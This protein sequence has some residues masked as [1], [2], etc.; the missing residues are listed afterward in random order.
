MTVENAVTPAASAAA[1]TTETPTAAQTEQ[2]SSSSESHSDKR[3]DFLPTGKHYRLTGEMPKEEA[4]GD[5][6]AA[7]KVQSQKD[8]S[9]EEEASA[10]SASVTAAESETAQAQGKKTKL[11][12]EQRKEQLNAE[13]R[14]LTKQRNELRTPTASDVKAASSPAAEMKLAP[15]KAATPKPRIDDVDPKTNQPRFK[16]YADYEEAKDA[17]ISED[18]VR[19]V[20]EKSAKTA[21]EQQLA[22]VKQTIAREFQKKVDVGRTKYADF[23]AVAL[24]PDL[25][26][27]EGSVVDVF[28]VDS[29]HGQELLYHFGKN[30]QDLERINGMNQIRQAR[31]LTK[32]ELKYENATETDPAAD[33]KAAASSSAKPVTKAPR[34]PHQLSG[35]GTAAKDTISQAVQEGDQETYMREANARALARKRKG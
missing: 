6:E 10:A 33:E 25:P 31:E 4:A 28:L 9:S 3:A 1:T 19:K 29:P 34:P 16:T 11:T 24:N 2:S 26:I 35:K 14:L 21:K 15:V 12:A 7:G 8:T 22:S 23:D 13:I 18:A 30:P 17:W 20:E 5:E 32:L 27:K